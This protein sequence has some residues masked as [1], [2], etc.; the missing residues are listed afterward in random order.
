MAYYEFK[1]S[2]LST[3][4]K[5]EHRIYAFPPEASLSGDLSEICRQFCRRNRARKFARPKK[6]HSFIKRGEQSSARRA[7]LY[8]IKLKLLFLKTVALRLN[9]KIIYEKTFYLLTF[10]PTLNQL[11]I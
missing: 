2:R 5:T 10:F 7:S 9:L 11:V 4:S 1:Q 6:C 3:D 8:L